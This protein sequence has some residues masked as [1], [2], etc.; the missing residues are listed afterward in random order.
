MKKIKN[1]NKKRKGFSLVELMIVL[2]IMAVLIGIAMPNMTSLLGTANTTANDATAEA[3]KTGVI[4]WEIKS[5]RAMNNNDA[6]DYEEINKFL[7]EM[8]VGNDE[9]TSVKWKLTIDNEKEYTLKSPNDSEYN[10]F[11]MWKEEGSN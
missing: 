1:S 3:I 9:P 8:E 2:A 11:S 4:G 10:F 6:T 5:K 7:M